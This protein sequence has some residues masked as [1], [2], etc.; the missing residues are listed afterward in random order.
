MKGKKT[1]LLALSA[2]CLCTLLAVGGTYALFTGEVTYNHVISAGKLTVAFDELSSKVYELDPNTGLMRTREITTTPIDLTQ[3]TS[4][5]ELNGFVP[6]SYYETKLEIG[7]EGTTAFNYKINYAVTATN[8]ADQRLKEQ[9]K[10][11]LTDVT[12]ASAP[13][14]VYKKTLSEAEIYDTDISYL[15]VNSAKQ[16]TVRFEFVNNDSVNNAAQEGSIIIM[17]KLYATQKL[18][19]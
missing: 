6:H 17:I 11:T 13:V 4:T 1:L 7:N 19:E 2:L 15:T 5:V 9:I 14:E 8:E 10:V 12:N 3:N 18:A 16:Y